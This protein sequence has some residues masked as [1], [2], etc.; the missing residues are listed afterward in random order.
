MGDQKH[1]IDRFQVMHEASAGHSKFIIDGSHFSKSSSYRT[2][3][4]LS[5]PC[6]IA[7]GGPNERVKE[8]GCP[9]DQ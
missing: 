9:I 1:E 4:D 3:C 5:F 6:R 7:C 2:E 8:L